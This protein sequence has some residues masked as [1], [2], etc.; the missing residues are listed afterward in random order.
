MVPHTALQRTPHGAAELRVPTRVASGLRRQ[1]T[2][3]RR[4]RADPRGQHAAGIEPA[5]YW[6]APQGESL[7]R[8]NITG[9]A[10]KC[11]SR[12]QARLVRYRFAPKGLPRSLPVSC[13]T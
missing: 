13:S 6:Q 2:K 7:A 3:A 10:L 5:A 9:F 11:R 1:L 8:F 12:S 4:L